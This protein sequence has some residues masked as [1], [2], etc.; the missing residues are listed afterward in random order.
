MKKFAIVFLLMLSILMLTACK[1]NKQNNNQQPATDAATGSTE[2]TLTSPQ[3]EQEIKENFKPAGELYGEE[4]TEGYNIT[5]EYSFD[6][7]VDGRLQL[8]YYKYNDKDYIHTYDY[9]DESET[10]LI[11]TFCGDVLAAEKEFSYEAIKDIEGTKVIDGYYV[12]NPVT[13]TE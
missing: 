7:N 5:P 10:L 3:E 4:A 13:V 12:T 1:N 9:Y 2:P 6:Y 11:Y 8:V